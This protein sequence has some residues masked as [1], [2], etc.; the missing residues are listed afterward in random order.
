MNP[1]SLLITHKPHFSVPLKSS[2]Y[3][4]TIAISAVNHA[5]YFTSSPSFH[6]FTTFLQRHK[7]PVLKVEVARCSQED[8]V[9]DPKDAAL[10]VSTCITRNLAPALTLEQGLDCIQEAVEKL[11]ASPPSCPIGMVR[12]QVAVPPSP[13][14]L[15]WFCSQPQSG[16]VFPRFFLSKEENP[17]YMSLA[18][19]RTSGVFGIGAAVYFK[20]HYSHPS[21]E[22]S[23]FQ[24]SYPAMELDIPM[25]YGFLDVSFDVISSSMKYEAGSFY[26]FI[27]QI[28]L[29]ESEEVSVLVANLAWNDSSTSFFAKAIQTYE[30]A[31]YQA[32]CH[33]WSLMDDCSKKCINALQVYGTMKDK[34]AEMVC[35]SA[36]QIGGSL[37]DAGTLELKD[38]SRCS[39]QFSAMLS[40]LSAISNNMYHSDYFDKT[41]YSTLDCP[42]INSL[43]ASLIIE[44]CT[45]LGLTYICVAPGSRSSP[46]AIAAS[47]HPLTTCVACID[48][49]SLSFHA[50]GFVRGSH[51]PAVIITSSGT[52]ASNLLPAVV[53]AS[54]DF[55]P[56]ILL[57]ADRPPELQDVG[58]NQAINQVN[59]FGP[60]VRHFFG[61][62]APTD[63][64]SARTVLTTLD[65]AVNIATSSPCGPVHVNCPFREP[66]A[67]TPSIWN[68]SCLKGLDFWMSSTEP[69]TTYIEVQH[70]ISSARIH[71]DMDEVIKV[72]E[73]ADRGLLI[74]GAIHTVDD[75]WAALLL[76]K[77][78]LWPVV[79]DIL[80]GLRLRKYMA[81]FS[82]TEDDILFIDHLDH[83]LLSEKVRN[84]MKVDVV[85]QI[86]SRITSARIQEML[87]H[88]FPC[89][90]IMVDN[91]PRRHDPLHIVTHRIRST[92]TEFTNYLLKACSPYLCSKWNGYLRALDMMAAWEM[93]FLISSECS[94]TEPYVAHI[95]PEILDYESA[96]FLGNSMPI[97]DADMYGSNKAQNTHGALMLN[98]GLPCHWIQVVGNRGASGIDG[99][100]SAAVGF[101]VGCNKRVL[102]VIGDVSFLHDSNGLSLLGQGILRKPMTIVVIN[103]HGGAI[104]SLLPIA[105]M[106]ERR[107]LDQFFYTS[108]NV[109]IHNLCLANGVKHVQVHTKMDLLDSLFTSQC[110]KVDCV[111]EVESCIDANAN[112]HSD[113]RKFSRQA[114]EQTMDIFS[115]ST[116]VTTGQVQGFIIGR[117]TKMDY[118]LYR[119]NLCAPPT[120]TSG[121]NESTTFYREGFVLSLSLEDGSTGYGEV[122]PLEIHKENLLD[123]EEQLRFL[124]H[125]LEGAKI[126]YFL[127]LLK[128]SFSAWIWHTLGILPSSILPSVRCGL[129]MAVLNAVAAKEGSSMLNILFPKTV[130]LPK[131]FLNVHICALI[132]S[133]G[134]PLDTAYIATSLVKEGFIAVKM[135]VARRANVIEDIAVIQ[136]VRRKVGDQVELRVD[137]NRNWTYDEAIQFANSVKNCRL[138]YIEEPVRY[139]DDIIKFCEE[140][141]L[142]VALDETVNCIR[143]NPFDV[144]N[145]FNHSG[146]VAIVIK[147]SLIGGFENA[148]LVARWAQQQGKMAVVSATFESGLGLSSYVQFSCYLDLQS[149]DICRLMDKEPSACIAHG[150]GTYRWFTEDVTLEPLNICCNSK[151]GIVEACATDA[152]QHL[153]HFQINQNVVVQNFDQENV[154]NYRLTVDLEGFSFSFNVLEMGQSIAGNVVVFLHGFLGTGQDWIPIMKAMSR[155]ARC[156]AIDLPG[157]GGS[158]LKTDSA[159]KPSLSIHVI[160]EMLCQLFPH[161]TPE[162]VILV[163][164]SMG[165]RVALHMA[166]KCS[167][168]EAQD[169]LIHWQE[170]CEGLG[171]ISE[172]VP[173]FLM[174]LSSF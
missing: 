151:T 99:L 163:G 147:P 81:C 10:L 110:E 38:A 127:P 138:Q 79:V 111:I 90:Y 142:P 23:E 152:G 85:I 42:N 104:F 95:L 168:K 123:V 51:S 28:E 89:S 29:H 126:D 105:A 22:H 167:D 52:A 118:S 149:A 45:R 44:E 140:T 173:L 37:L 74:L 130:D 96:V 56:L 170:S 1:C 31:L 59:H 124:I 78:L 143:E 100:L 26:L 121:S 120:S 91:H 7:N 128:G 68:D 77:H 54:Q 24:R 49:R 157:H 71:A 165:A 131:K 6:S 164:Y 136:E 73:R 141:G 137:A 112:F 72:I 53:E 35:M 16:G 2:L 19:G 169:W 61:L 39:S 70:S 108:H 97:R 166:L 62:P 9:L 162:K 12:F 48:E 4:K 30:I 27:P 146:V 94:L 132:D 8:A 3:R 148:S 63:D 114:A 117:I 40:P 36:F 92:S 133:V 116:S 158:K 25:A 84:W 154:H 161:I 102:C 60:F 14:A 174:G 80:S 150:L 103:N 87:E 75:I 155:S 171:M 125:M 139:D 32:R 67:K 135:K 18:L 66:L 33:L 58:A 172:Q 106:T 101:A 55:L 43:W 109:S 134:S 5:Y 144:L 160:A 88:S 15:K 57:T 98:L 153:Q 129:E 41:G 93:S 113:L 156:I 122:A 86:G 65:S 17:S 64:I 21:R 145:R 82:N 159:A 115:L 46:L 69:F 107:V 20:G 50:V 119:V 34:I 47:A 83:L 76:A 13:K 11:K